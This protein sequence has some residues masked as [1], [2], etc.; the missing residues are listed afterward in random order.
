MLQ[1]VI[2]RKLTEIR[3]KRPIFPTKALH[4]HPTKLVSSYSPML[5]FFS[6][7]SKTKDHSLQNKLNMNSNDVTPLKNT[8]TLQLSKNIVIKTHYEKPSPTTLP[9]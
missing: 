5:S 6:P 3:A 4:N 7:S 8:P 9:T 1:L 2:V